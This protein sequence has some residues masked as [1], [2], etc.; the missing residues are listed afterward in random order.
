MTIQDSALLESWKDS[1]SSE[2][3]KGRELFFLE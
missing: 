2:I 1:T 3:D